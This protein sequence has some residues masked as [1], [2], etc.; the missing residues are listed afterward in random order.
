MRNK[1][2]QAVQFS[3]T[4]PAFCEDGDRVPAKRTHPY[5]IARDPR[6]ST[7]SVRTN[8][9][10]S[11]RGSRFQ[12]M[13]LYVRESLEDRAVVAEIQDQLPGLADELCGAIHDFLQDGPDAAAFGRMAHR[14]E[15]AGQAQLADQ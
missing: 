10:G 15:F 2:A 1:N 8:S 3:C 7:P 12:K 5:L 6:C 14:A 9:P 13:Q 11:W 4:F